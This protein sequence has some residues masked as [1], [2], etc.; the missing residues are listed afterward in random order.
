MPRVFGCAT[1]APS[2]WDC[3]DMEEEIKAAL[4]NDSVAQVQA[5]EVKFNRALKEAAE[6]DYLHE[7]AIPEEVGGFKRQIFGDAA[8]L[9]AQ[10]VVKCSPT[11]LGCSQTLTRT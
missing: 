8:H 2:V 10:E 5:L 7:C 9:G 4:Q 3:A 11:L 6:E 1:M